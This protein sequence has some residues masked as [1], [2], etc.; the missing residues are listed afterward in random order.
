MSEWRIREWL[1]R[2]PQILSLALVGAVI[3]GSL[4]L[5]SGVDLS[6]IDPQGGGTYVGP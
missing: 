6:Y 5:S 4:F 1:A 2:N 3:A